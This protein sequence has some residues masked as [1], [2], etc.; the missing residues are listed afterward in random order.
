MRWKKG[1]GKRKKKNIYSKKVE[2]GKEGR[3]DREMEETEINILIE[4]SEKNGK[5]DGERE[6]ENRKGKRT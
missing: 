6:R 3:K 5:N 4:E 2:E 1:K